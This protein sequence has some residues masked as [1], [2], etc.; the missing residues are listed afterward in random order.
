M[1]SLLRETAIFFVTVA[2]I[3]TVVTATAQH[4]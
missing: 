3:F 2:F 4:L 1:T